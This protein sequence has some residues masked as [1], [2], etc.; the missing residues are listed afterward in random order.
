MA[1]RRVTVDSAKEENKFVNIFLL[2]PE[3]GLTDA[4]RSAMFTK[5]DITDLRMRRFLQRALPGGS[6]KGLKAYIAGLLPLPVDPAATAAPPEEVAYRHKRTPPPH[7]PVDPAATAPP[8]KE[9]IIDSGETVLSLLSPGTAATV[10][11]DKHKQWNHTFYK[12]KKKKMVGLFT[13]PVSMDPWAVTSSGKVHMPTAKKMAKQRRVKP[14][15]DQIINAGNVQLQ[16]AILCALADHPALAPAVE[17][18]GIATSRAI[19]AAK[20]V[21]TQPACMMECAWSAIKLRGNKQQQKRDAAEVMLT[22][23][24]PS[25]VRKAGDPSRRDR[26]CALGIPQSTLSRVKKHMIEKQ[27]LLSAGEMGIH[28]VL[29]KKKKGYSKIS[30]E[31]KLLL[32]NA[33]HDH[34]HV[35]V[36]PNTKDT[37]QVKNADGEKVM[38]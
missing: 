2:M 6:I 8:L 24:A 22:F 4:M 26:A 19:A 5:E 28:W 38:V 11:K 18:A 32:V 20:F 10:C 27:R 15:V 7:F 33:F 1:S 3:T 17:V 9:V 37:L 29:A 36:L 16:A 30:N 21:C 31:L 14:S 13:S 23:T 25:L 34:P 12:N 35:V